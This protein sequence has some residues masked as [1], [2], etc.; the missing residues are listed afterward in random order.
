VLQKVSV[1]IQKLPTGLKYILTCLIVY[2]K[3]L[4][5]KN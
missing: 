4:D 2:L 5:S 1:N 3:I